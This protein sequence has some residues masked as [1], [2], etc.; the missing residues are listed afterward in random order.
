M[1]VRDLSAGVSFTSAILV[2]ARLHTVAG[3]VRVTLEPVQLRN[4]HA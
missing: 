1:I 2:L 4:W 3:T